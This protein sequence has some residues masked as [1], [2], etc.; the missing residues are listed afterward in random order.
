MKVA[1]KVVWY[2]KDII[3]LG[4]VYGSKLKDKKKTKTSTV[5]FPFGLI[6]YRNN[7]YVGDP[8]DS[9]LVIGYCYF[10]NKVIISQYSKK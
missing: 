3:Y 7:D 6:G 1:K 9:K 4:L 5:F 2:L 8:K 10:I